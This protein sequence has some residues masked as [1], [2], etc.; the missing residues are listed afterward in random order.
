LIAFGRRD[1]AA[2][3]ADAELAQDNHGPYWSGH[4]GVFEW[5]SLYWQPPEA[6]AALRASLV[7]PTGVRSSPRPADHRSRS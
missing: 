2:A 5:L 7:P 6:M 3:M 4:A 1:Q